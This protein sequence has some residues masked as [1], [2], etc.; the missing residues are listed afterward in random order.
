MGM[1]L[2]RVLGGVLAAVVAMAA[3]WALAWYHPRLASG[4]MLGSIL[5]GWGW[6]IIRALKTGIVT[7]RSGRYL[8]ANS[9]IAY[10]GWLVFFITMWLL[11]LLGVGAYTLMKS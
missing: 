10:W 8:R 4:L 2:L 11:Y 7:V 6:F 1:S 3:L 5:V 9:P